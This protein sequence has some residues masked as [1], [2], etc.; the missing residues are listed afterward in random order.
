M[1]SHKNVTQ[2]KMRGIQDIVLGQ[3]LQSRFYMA[4]VC[5]N[6]CEG[7]N[8]ISS[9]C[10]SQDTSLSNVYVCT[11]CHETDIVRTHCIPFKPSRY[12]M[13]SDDVKQALVHRYCAPTAKEFV[14]RKCDKFL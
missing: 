1:L 11:C 14:C 9:L 4:K 13:T 7:A 5:K 8:D 2:A 12:N 10:I 6:N 3:M